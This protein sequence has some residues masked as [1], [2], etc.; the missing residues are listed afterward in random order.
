MMRR[1]YLSSTVLFWLAVLAFALA[2]LWWDEAPRAQE[3]SAPQ[4]RV[5]T[6]AEV[7]RHASAGDCW[8]VIDGQVYDFTPYVA[9]H[10]AEPSILLAWCGKE[11]SEAYR[12]KTRGRPHSPYADSLLPTYRIGPLVT[13]R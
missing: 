6:L 7:A 5:L 9:K 3:R 8:M 12:T 1:L 4:Q 13:A 11:A 2:P 10:P